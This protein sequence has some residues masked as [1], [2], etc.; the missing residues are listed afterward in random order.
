M[1]KEEKADKEQG[2]VAEA[3]S[4][5]EKGGKAKGSGRILRLVLPAGVVVVG[6]LAGFLVSIMGRSAPRQAAAGPDERQREQ[7]PPANEQKYRYYDLD[8]IIVNL[9]E[10]RLT[11]YIRAKL[12]LAIST[13]DY[14]AAEE[15]I[16]R[17]MSD[18]RNW[19][20]IYLADCSIEDVRGAAKL[21]RILRDIQDTLNQRL[22]PGGR[23]LIVRVD[24][25]EWVI[26]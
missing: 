23:P 14:K 7:Q 13:D 25:D 26:Q 6:A 3:L 11:R 16:E 20:I 10:P 22:W 2:S 19:L 21:N 24:Y 12:R 17:R 4:E 8:P 1:A 9:N 15:T 18:V 5:G